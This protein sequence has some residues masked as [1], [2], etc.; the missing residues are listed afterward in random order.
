MRSKNGRKALKRRI[1]RK[2]V[3]QMV[4]QYKHS[5]R[6][7]TIGL[8]LTLIVFLGAASTAYAGLVN[9]VQ[10]KKN[11]SDAV[12]LQLTTDQS[13]I[14]KVVIGANKIEFRVQG[15]SM[16]DTGSLKVSGNDDV[17]EIFENDKLVC[18]IPVDAVPSGTYK[19]FWC[20]ECPPSVRASRSPSP[21][22]NGWNNSNVTITVTADDK[23]GECV[24]SGIDAIYYKIGTKSP[25]K[26][27]TNRLTM[28]Q[29]GQVATYSLQVSEEG[30]QYVSFWARDK[31]GN[32]STS[33]TL[34][35]KID[36]G[37]PSIYVS[38]SSGTYEDRLAVSWRA[39]DGLSGVGSCR[40]YVDGNFHSSSADGSYTFGPGSHSIRVE[41]TDKAG[42]STSTSR[43]YTIESKQPAYFDVTSL[44]VSDKSPEI[45]ESV[46]VTATI[47]NTG[48]ESG[49]KTVTFYISGSYK[50]SKSLTLSAGESDTV[51]FSCYFYSSGSY[52]LMVKTPDDSRS[53]TITVPPA[54]TKPAKFGMSNLTISPSSP[55]VDDTVSISAKVTNTGE[56]SASQYIRLIINNKEKKEERI[57]LAPGKSTT[58]SFSYT[59]SSSGSYY[60]KVKSEDDYVARTV[61]VTQP[62]EGPTIGFNI[63]FPFFHIYIGT[64][65]EGES[66]SESFGGA[67][68][69]Q[70]VRAFVVSTSP[71]W[72]GGHSSVIFDIAIE[73]LDT[74]A[75]VTTAIL[76]GTAYDVRRAA[77]GRSRGTIRLNYTIRFE[78]MPRVHRVE[79]QLKDAAGNYSNKK[80]LELEV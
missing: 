60:V 46:A 7:L 49:R 35:V 43:S 16:L 20:D 29:E 30:T 31:A 11:G 13:G 68:A 2:E 32:E 62:S 23:S 52:T 45:E 15:G 28:S 63:D 65:S 44:S 54:P 10:A 41:A 66:P 42:N 55:E 40:V 33:E 38:K 3:F 69:P 5:R 64:P 34:T 70:I 58:V 67:H 57:S 48:D 36:K 59:F 39:S 21:N 12:E 76:G 47:K 25:V 24:P 4:L 6:W 18:R 37:K 26:V 56:N 78:G 27:G 50:D 73:F 75:D 1:L 71:S 61:E 77:Y 19:K 51:R 22:A 17:I 8:I 79:V 80:I 9:G 53:T 14:V 72:E 74:D